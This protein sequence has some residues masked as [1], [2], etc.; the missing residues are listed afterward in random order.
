MNLI[1]AMRETIEALERLNVPY[2]VVE[3]ISS[4]FYSLSR[5]TT[6]VDFVV[7]FEGNSLQN[8]ITNLGPQ[9]RF[10][11]QM[12]FET[13]TGTVRNV[14]AVKDTPFKIEIFRL[15]DDPHDQERFRRRVQVRIYD[16]DVSIPTVE[17]VIIW[18]LRW[19]RPKDRDDL[20]YVILLQGTAIDWGYVHH[21]CDQHEIRE[22]LNEIRRSLPSTDSLEFRSGSLQ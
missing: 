20:R 19:G 11:R 10:E 18:K 2:M 1:G 8:F 7:A 4:M 3:S 16:I 17:D 21:W 5:T 22:L 13:L 6:D 9:F 14:I 15:S 12:S